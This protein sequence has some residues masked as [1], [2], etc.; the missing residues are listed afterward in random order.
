MPIAVYEVSDTPC[1]SFEVLRFL[2]FLE[3]WVIYFEKQH[4]EW[5]D[6]AW[7][8]NLNLLTRV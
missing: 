1:I 8:K 6:R 3:R 7:S 4:V 5:D 2:I